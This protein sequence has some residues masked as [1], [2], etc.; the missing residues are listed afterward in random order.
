VKEIKKW[1]FL[2]MDDVEIDVVTSL[3]SSAPISPAVP[4]III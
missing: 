1:M 2:L 3:L 4:V